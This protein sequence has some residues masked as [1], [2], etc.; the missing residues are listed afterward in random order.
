MS[1]YVWQ[2]PEWASKLNWSGTALLSPLSAAHLAQGRL[3]GK[4]EHLGVDLGLR[5]RT[6][7]LVEEAMQTSA[8]EGER[9]DRDSVRSSVARR[10]GLGG[11]LVE[12]SRPVDGLVAMLMDATSDVTRPLTADRLKGW[13]AAMFPTGYSGLKQITVGD[14]RPGP[15]PMRVVSGEWG[16]P[17]HVHFE[18]VPPE[19]VDGDMTDFLTWF[20]TPPSMNGMVRAGVA[21]V[22]LLTIHPFED[23][24]GRLTRA[25]TELALAQDEGTEARLWSLSAQI[26]TERS[27]YYSEL[28]RAQRGDGD[29]TQ[30][31][32]WFIGCCGR[33]LKRS[34][35]E[36][37]RISAK[38]RFWQTKGLV[39]LNPRQAK[40]LT[41]M[42]D[43][44]P[45]GFEGGMTR[46][47]YIG[48]TKSTRSTAQRDLADLL[49]RG[50]LVQRPGGGRSA[51]YD[52]NWPHDLSH[53]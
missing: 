35:R 22:H 17:A 46:R 14:W 11:A 44:G 23:G 13:H 30:W 39:S 28:E 16:N 1:E 25:V 53:G 4:A 49:A 32:A 41:R 29:V 51:S 48:L 8:I 40:V 27:D 3:L 52:V 31:L 37:D 34:E 18:A 9:L 21:H 26:Q 7:A 45:G 50:L 6:N 38:V 20:N 2:R 33:A 10:L 12:P 15:E 19:Q 5:M 42:L 36:L 47:K 43:A 24:N